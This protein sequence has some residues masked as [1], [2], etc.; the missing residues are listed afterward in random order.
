MYKKLP[1]LIQKPLPLI[2]LQP[3]DKKAIPYPNGMGPGEGKHLECI[4]L[5]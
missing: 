4:P 1:Q 2:V 3:L 5:G